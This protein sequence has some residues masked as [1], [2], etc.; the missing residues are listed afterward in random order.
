MIECCV[1][2]MAYN[3][4]KNIG[5]MLEAVLAQKLDGVDITEIVVV[6][7]GCTDHTEEIVN[8]Y[9]ERDPHIRLLHQQERCGKS[10][11]INL[12]LRNTAADVIVLVNADT[13]PAPEALDA[14]VK[15]F[16]DD[17][18]GMTG[19]H[20]VPLNDE[21]TFMGYSA[22]LLWRLHHRVCLQCP[23][24]GEMIAFRNF[25]HQIPPDSAVD[26]ASIEPLI[27][28]QGLRLCYVPGAIVYNQGPTTLE[29]F[30]R[31]RRRIYAG[32]T[33]VRETLGYRVATMKGLRILWLLLRH[34]EVRRDW[35]YFLWGPLVVTLEV[36]ARLRGALDY[37]LWKRKHTVWEIAETT[38][39]VTA[40][41]ERQQVS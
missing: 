7:S 36:V 40:V 39:A 12:L 4:E 25:F 35:R 38:K 11:A 3:E 2:T 33:Y 6:A 41:P 17:E 13:I 9:A 18:V 10:S 26:E 28:G 21:R 19:G 8:Q 29:D 16:E 5:R 23:K 27:R 14:L 34:P 30:F 32:H 20:P 15:P 37:R 31:Q 24:M 1:A 22:H